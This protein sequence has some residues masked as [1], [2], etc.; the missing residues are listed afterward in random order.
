M[1]DKIH[2]RIEDIINISVCLLNYRVDGTTFLI[3]FLMN[4][5]QGALG[6]VKNYVG[7]Q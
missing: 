6:N 5:L 4:T 2:R 7:V 1:V 3:Q